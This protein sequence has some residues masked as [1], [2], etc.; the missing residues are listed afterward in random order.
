MEEIPFLKRKKKRT[1][2]LLAYHRSN[3]ARTSIRQ[4]SRVS[5]NFCSVSD[6]QRIL[7]KIFNQK[8]TKNGRFCSTLFTRTAYYLI[9]APTCIRYYFANL[10]SLRFLILVWDCRRFPMRSGENTS[11]SAV[12]IKHLQSFRERIFAVVAR[13]WRRA[14]NIID[15]NFT[16]QSTIVHICFL[17][18]PV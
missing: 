14:A 18:S 11:K 17:S 1:Y 5:N 4:F 3:S 2:P 6:C 10:I 9:Q 8:S 15:N 16:L 13:V 7:R 12:T